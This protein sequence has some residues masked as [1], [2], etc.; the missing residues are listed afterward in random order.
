TFMDNDDW[1][2]RS[3]CLDIVY[4]SLTSRPVDFLCHM[5]C[6]A[7]FDG[8]GV[9]SGLVIGNDA[10]KAGVTIHM[11]QEIDWPRG[12]RSINDI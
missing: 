12:K 11:A 10:V 7:S 6:D 9:F 4:A 5:N 3:D 1:W 2:T 8:V